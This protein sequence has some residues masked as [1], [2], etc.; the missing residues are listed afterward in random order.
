[1]LNGSNLAFSRYHAARELRAVRGEPL[2]VSARL[3]LHRETANNTTSASQRP[4]KETEPCGRIIRRGLDRGGIQLAPLTAM[5]LQAVLG[6]QRQL[7]R[8]L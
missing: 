7:R 8:R 5:V 2:R 4:G 1:M 6:R 3:A